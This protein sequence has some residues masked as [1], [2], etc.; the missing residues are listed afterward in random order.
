V[1]RHDVGVA[2]DDHDLLR[3]G[4]LAL[5]QVD[6][7][8]D[9]RLLV[10]GRLGGVE[11]LGALV[12]LEQLA[13][14]EAHGVARDLADRPDEP[15]PEPVVDTA[16]GLLAQQAR[17]DELGLGEAAPAQVPQ[18]R[19]PALRCVPDAELLGGAPVETALGEERA[20][21][22][23]ARGR[24]LLGEVAGRSTV[25]LE[26]S[27]AAAR[28]VTRARCAALLVPQLD[29]DAAC[30]VLD[31]VRERQAVD[32]LDERDDVTALAAPE[33]VP[34]ADLRTHVE[35]RRVL[36]VERAEALHRP[37]A[38]GLQGHVLADDVL[39][40]G[41]FADRLHVVPPDPSCHGLSLGRSGP[42]PCALAA[43][44]D[45][46]DRLVSASVGGRGARA[47]RRPTRR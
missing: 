45:L 18:E 11:V 36:V 40:M 33:A 42:S 16:A 9:L 35:R 13:S 37:D 25:R 41:T 38:R 8:Q 23:T 12:L 43:G 10:E 20:R 22:R 17:R 32:L 34:Q 28:L 31:G 46:P 44:P 3:T 7:V 1:H 30:E 29:A 24:E 2:L 21:G 4:D 26:Q 19:V 6:A 15:S 14:P 47:S 39:D 27:L 5:R